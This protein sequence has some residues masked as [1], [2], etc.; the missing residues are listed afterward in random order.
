MK[1]GSQGKQLSIDS[2]RSSLEGL[3]KSNRRVQSGE[4]LPWDGIEGC[5]TI[6]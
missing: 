2:F 3:S 4:M 5:I 6:V 1:Y